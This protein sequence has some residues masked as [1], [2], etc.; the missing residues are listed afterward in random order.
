MQNIELLCASE[1]ISV[2][3]QNKLRSI[4]LDYYKQGILESNPRGP[5]RYR[6]K[7]S[8]TSFCT[9][10]INQLG[11]RIRDLFQLGNFPVDPH[12]GWIISLI[13]KGGQIHP[14]IDKYEYHIKNNAKHLRCNILV[15]RE[16]DTANP[17]ID[18]KVLDV[19]ERC[20]WGFFPSEVVH[21]TQ[22]LDVVEPRIVFQFGFLV[23]KDYQLPD[24]LTLVNRSG[25]EVS[26]VV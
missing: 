7:I 26:K 25:D 4:A 24:N 18:G 15:T 5:H 2:D 10:F 14:H 6:A 22:L 21:S 17:V 13:E 20:L 9:P 16:N 8:N 23:P 12:L 19:N 3:E 1:F 11:E